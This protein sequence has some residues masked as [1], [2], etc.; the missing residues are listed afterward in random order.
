MAG[1]PTATVTFLYTDTKGS[2]ARWEAQPPVMRMAVARHD[3]LLRQAISVD[4]GHVFRMMG[5]SLCAAGRGAL[6]RGSARQH[7][8]ARPHHHRRLG[9]VER[10]ATAALSSVS[11][12]TGGSRHA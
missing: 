11:S 5:D 8:H 6:A 7:H 3:A 12:T 1:L 2:T 4:H 10:T 9:R